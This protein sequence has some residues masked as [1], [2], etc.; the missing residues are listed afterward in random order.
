MQGQAE[1]E[2]LGDVFLRNEDIRGLDISMNQVMAVSFL[3][4]AG[5]LVDEFTGAGHA[6]GPVGNQLFE[7]RADHAFH[8]QIME[9]MRLM[10]KGPAAARVEGTHDVRVANARQ[11]RA[12]RWQSV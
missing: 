10:L 8:D 3:E 7:I 4:S 5:D 6:H 2:Q 11:H 12:S 1:I 9:T